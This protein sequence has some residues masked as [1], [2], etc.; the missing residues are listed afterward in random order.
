M[1]QNKAHEWIERMIDGEEIPPDMLAFIQQS[2]E[3][4]EY[5]TALENAV[6][7]LDS[8]TFPD[9]PENLVDDIM[10]Y[11]QARKMETAAPLPTAGNRLSDWWE[12]CRSILSSIQIPAVLRREA[13]PV[14][15]VALV[16]FIGIFSPQ[17]EAEKAS[18]LFESPMGRKVS[19]YVNWMAEKSDRI[20]D[21]AN[22]NI[23]GLI[24]QVTGAFQFEGEKNRKNTTQ[25]S[26]K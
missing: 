25:D 8:L 22:Q 3:C 1:D 6:S 23:S 21:Y 13:V 7:A 5:Q 4:L 26:Q 16:I 2:P 12:W 11:I 20:Y 24:D 14:M 18:S 19:S 17:V 9:P 15:A 10:I